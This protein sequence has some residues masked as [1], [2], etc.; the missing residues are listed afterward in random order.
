MHAL[1]WSP[2]ER[3]FPSLGHLDVLLFLKGT[4]VSVELGG[5]ELD[6]FFCDSELALDA[7]VRPAP[8][9]DTSV[10]EEASVMSKK[11][12]PVISELLGSRNFSM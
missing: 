5:E 7:T 11:R 10:L 9:T 2:G 1:W 8:D 4:E 6:T 12:E 3:A